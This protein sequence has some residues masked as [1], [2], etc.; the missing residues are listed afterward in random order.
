MKVK[1]SHR[2]TLTLT[3]HRL[4]SQTRFWRVEGHPELIA[5][6]YFNPKPEREQKLQAMAASLPLQLYEQPTLAWPLDLLYEDD[7]FVGYLMPRIPN[8]VP[9]SYGYD[10][11]K[12]RTTYPGFTW[13]QLHRVG[14]NMM[15]AAQTVHASGH[16]IGY[17]HENN[18]LVNRDAW[19]TLVGTDSFQISGRERVY[20]SRGRPLK[21]APPEFHPADVLFKPQ[22]D[23]FSLAVLLFML[24]ME[25]YHPFAT[26]VSALMSRTHP[27]PNSL[28]RGYFPFHPA[29]PIS[30]PETAPPFA[31]LHPQIQD[32]FDRC[33]VAGYCQPR[34]RPDATEWQCLLTEAEANLVTCTHNDHHVYSNHLA[35]C[36]WCQMRLVRA[37]AIPRRPQLRVPQSTPHTQQSPVKSIGGVWR[38]APW[39][40]SVTQRWLWWLAL[41]LWVLLLLY[42][43]LS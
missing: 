39:N 13:Q 20:P 5:K 16:L 28:R 38:K 12:R 30:P 11:A 18:I 33:F 2:E 10:P 24:L 35:S 9:L 14:I 34:Q 26:P 15:T 22:H 4:R 31:L 37:E 41:Y 42:L 6:V 32:A 1:T 19:V 17:I 29:S 8:S 23:Y 27:D 25:G 40:N 7:Q 36:P 21:Y 43:S 3:S